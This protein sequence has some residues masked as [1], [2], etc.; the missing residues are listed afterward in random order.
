MERACSPPE[1]APHQCVFCVG[2][3][4]IGA[5]GRFRRPVAVVDEMEALASL[6]FRWIRVED[7]LF[8]FH[9]ERALAICKEIARTGLT[10]RWR[11]YA[12]VDTVD[13]ELLRCG[14]G[15]VGSQTTYQ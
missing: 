15:D 4:M 5:K 6:G 10:V 8:T 3:K 7:D 11:T 9:H 12:R 13:P 1:D 2:R 14:V